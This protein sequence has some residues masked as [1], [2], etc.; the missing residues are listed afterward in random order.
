LRGQRPRDE[1]F[2]RFLH[3]SEVRR[4]IEAADMLCEQFEGIGL[5]PFSVAGRRLFSDRTSIRLSRALS[6]G[7]RATGL[8]AVVNWSADVAMFIC[9][10][11]T[12]ALESSRP[13]KTR[14]TAQEAR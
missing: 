8:S 12:P 14:P 1:G 2:G 10:P 13:M 9:R 4:E 7:L 5:G 6:D 11:K 3:P